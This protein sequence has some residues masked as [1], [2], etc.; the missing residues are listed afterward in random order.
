MA[1]KLLL[2]A[3]FNH[4]VLPPQITLNPSST[5]LSR[6]DFRRQEGLQQCV[7]TDEKTINEGLAERLIVA[8]NSMSAFTDPGI[9]QSISACLKTTR[10]VNRDLMSMSSVLT[11]LAAVRDSPDEESWISLHIGKQNVSLILHK[12]SK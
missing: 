6:D 12:D 1:Q 3:I 2:E 11:G 8:C 7:E 9:W 5:K 4:L 10:L